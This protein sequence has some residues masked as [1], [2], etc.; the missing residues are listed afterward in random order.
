MV[1]FTSDVQH[2]AGHD[3]VVGDALSWLPVAALVPPSASPAVTSD[4]RK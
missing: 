4:L 1:E 3:N 2:V